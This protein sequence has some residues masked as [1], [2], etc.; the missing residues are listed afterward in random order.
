M[1]RSC[2]AYRRSFVVTDPKPPLSNLHVYLSAVGAEEFAKTGEIKWYYLLVMPE[3]FTI[4]EG[5]I[6]VSEAL[7]LKLPRVDT[8]VVAA[9]AGLRKE[10]ER[11]ERQA[12]VE[13]DSL[14]TRIANIQLIGYTPPSSATGLLND[15]PLPD[16]LK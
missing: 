14:N 16:S 12:R 4:P 6:R 7:A 5:H 2:S 15:D 11:A 1:L 10:I 8:A 13:I 3:S 9:T